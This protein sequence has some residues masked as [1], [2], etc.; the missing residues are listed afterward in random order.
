MSY[1]LYTCRRDSRL[2]TPPI[3]AMADDGR[4]V[5]VAVDLLARAEGIRGPT[6][7]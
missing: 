2:A 4:G 1:G 5:G 6:V 7:D 3:G